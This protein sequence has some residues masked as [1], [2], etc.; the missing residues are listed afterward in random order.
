MQIKIATLED[1][2]GVFK[3]QEKYHLNSISVENKRNGFVTVKFTRQQFSDLIS[4]EKGLFVVIVKQQVV[5][6]AVAASWGYCSAWP[7]FD[8]VARK[9]CEFCY[10]NKKLSVENT[11]QY[12]PV[13][14]DSSIR[15]TGTFEG[16]FKVATREISEKY[17]TLIA[18][19][20]KTN[21]RSFAA[22]TTKTGFDTIDEFRYND[23]TY[24]LLGYDC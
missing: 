13:C 1:L 3:L 11:F 7:I 6:Y 15:G 20:N 12:G 21:P 22:A 18:F 10:S 16:I 5:G 17:P 4:N 8:F 14:L 2:E 9:L 23:N 24:Y 19:I